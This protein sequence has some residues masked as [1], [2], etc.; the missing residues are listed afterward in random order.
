MASTFVATGVCTW[1]AGTDGVVSAHA[2]NCTSRARRTQSA[3][4]SPAIDDRSTD[5]AT[6]PAPDASTACADT[7]RPVT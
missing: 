5:T 3:P 7:S 2:G 6:R 4:Y 1:H